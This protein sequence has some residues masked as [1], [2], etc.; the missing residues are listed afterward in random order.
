MKVVFFTPVAQAGGA[1][2]LLLD[3]A[4]GMQRRGHDVQLLIAGDGPLSELAVQRQVAV[5]TVPGLQL[6][7]PLA[8]LSAARLF[9]RHMRLHRPE[10]IIASHP[11]GHLFAALNCTGW[12]KE[13]VLAGIIYDAPNIHDPYDRVSLLLQ[14]PRIAIAEETASQ[15]AGL[16]RG[17]SRVLVIP[18][19]VDIEDIRMAAAK[20]SSESIF[21][22]AGLRDRTRPAVVMT[23][24]LQAFKGPRIFIELAHKLINAGVEANFIHVGPDAPSE[25]DLRRNLRR[26]IYDLGLEGVVGLA[27]YVERNDLAALVRDAVCTVHPA[28]NETFGL[29]LVESLAQGT[30]FVAFAGP[31][32]DKIAAAAGYTVA[33]GDIDT[34]T[35]LVRRLIASPPNDIEKSNLL[36]AARRFDVTLI[37]ERWES[38]IVDIAGVSS[39]G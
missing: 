17:K 27:G 38:A 30:P 33:D 20:G 19:C 7:N 16:I 10:V 13:M 8:V 32:P 34:M 22:A 37:D 3:T 23:S 6:H 18:P 26:L 31:G 24:R 2:N 39:Y 36:S 11:K 14:I 29:V 5:S 4:R 1:E 21:R 28:T 35:I 12:K 25:P 15:Y 9:R